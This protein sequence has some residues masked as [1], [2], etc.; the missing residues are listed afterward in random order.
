MSSGARS[1]RAEAR[2]SPLAVARP[3]K[4]DRRPIGGRGA[5]CAGF[6]R[7]GGLA[8]S[9]LSAVQGPGDID[10]VVISPTGIAIETK[11]WSYDRRHLAR[12]RKQAASLSR[13]RRR[14]ARND[15]P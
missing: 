10:S 8:A 6:S 3:A 4:S 5:A 15:A 9:A 12:L 2:R 11:T 1:R 13:R 7:G 14:W